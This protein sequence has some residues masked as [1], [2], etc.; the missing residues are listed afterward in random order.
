MTS[1]VHAARE[2]L[3]LARVRV[4]MVADVRKA[5][6]EHGHAR[7]LRLI[8]RALTAAEERAATA[9]RERDEARALIRRV[10]SWA[11][12]RCPCDNDLPRICPLCDADVEGKVN[13]GRCKA[14]DVSFPPALLS[15]LRRAAALP[16]G[17]DHGG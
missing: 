5:T 8:D 3:R 7:D 12:Q 13:D 10:T 15:D 4:G 9:E 17:A 11:A 16:S 6:G 14:M 1:D 2:E